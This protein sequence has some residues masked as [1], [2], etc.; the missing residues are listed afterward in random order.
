MVPVN[1]SSVSEAAPSSGGVLLAPRFAPEFAVGALSRAA[2][3]PEN[4]I[5]NISDAQLAKNQQNASAQQPSAEALAKAA[6]AV[7]GDTTIQIQP[8]ATAA[9]PNRPELPPPDPDEDAWL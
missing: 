3:M 6:A 7:G 8:E 9:D 1:I 4:P 2:A 5:D